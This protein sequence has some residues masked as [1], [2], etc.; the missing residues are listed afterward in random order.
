MVA[1]TVLS[2]YCGISAMSGMMEMLDC[3][4]RVKSIYQRSL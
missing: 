2:G 4:A 1:V 3:G